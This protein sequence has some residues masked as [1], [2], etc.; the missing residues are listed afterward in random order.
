MGGPTTEPDRSV[1]RSLPLA[2]LLAASHAETRTWSRGE[3]SDQR[4]GL[5]LLRRAIAA[6]DPMAWQAFVEQ[7]TNF[8][9]AHIHRNAA[10]AEVAEDDRF[11][12][13]RTFQRFAGAITPARLDQFQHVGA[14]LRYL[15]M[16][17]QSV[18]LDE[19]RRRR[20]RQ[21]TSLEALSES[22][23]ARVDVEQ[24]VIATAAAQ[25]VWGTIV[26]ELQDESEQLVARLSFL[27]GYKPGEIHAQHRDRFSSIGEV[28]RTKRRLL[29]RLRRSPRL[30][31]LQAGTVRY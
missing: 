5:E 18:L 11:W 26:G 9:L 2:V 4:F 15:A 31:R 1:V 19:L 10:H 17:A 12:V 30:L 6:E 20:R 25:E 29:E 27:Y 13:D 23:P 7:H 24:A 3:G 14:A 8:V 28:Y 22:I 21:H 16:C